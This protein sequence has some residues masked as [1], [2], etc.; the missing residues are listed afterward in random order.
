MEQKGASYITSF[1][2]TWY[3]HVAEDGFEVK[4]LPDTITF[5]IICASHTH[6]IIIHT[7]HYFF[8]A[9][10]GRVHR[11]ETFSITLTSA[12]LEAPLGLTFVTQSVTIT[13]CSQRVIWISKSFLPTWTLRGVILHIRACTFF[14]LYSIQVRRREAALRLLV[15]CSDSANVIWLSGRPEAQFQ[16]LATTQSSSGLPDQSVIIDYCIKK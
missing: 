14:M 13:I 1:K 12:T 8:R 16:V 9:E 6:L 7:R 15:G 3:P 2:N 5:S 4:Y 11:P 10:G